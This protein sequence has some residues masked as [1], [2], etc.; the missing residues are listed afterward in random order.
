MLFRSLAVAVAVEF[1][2]DL[3]VFLDTT[4]SAIKIIA[5]IIVTTVLEEDLDLGVDAL[6]GVIT[7][8]ATFGSLE[9]LLVAP[10]RV[11]TGGTV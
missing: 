8:S 7:R 4:N 10:E 3:V 6:A 11:G 2:S 5:A 9:I 1:V